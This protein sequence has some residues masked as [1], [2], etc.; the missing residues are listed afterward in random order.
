MIGC[1]TYSIN[2]RAS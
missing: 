2:H 1:C